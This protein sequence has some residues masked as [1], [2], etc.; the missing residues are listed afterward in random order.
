MKEKGR[1]ITDSNEAARRSDEIFNDDPKERMIGY[2]S[3]TAAEEYFLHYCKPDSCNE[4]YPDVDELDLV[5]RICEMAGECMLGLFS[6]NETDNP[7]EELE[8]TPT[9]VIK[10]YLEHLDWRRGFYI[11]SSYRNPELQ[12]LEKKVRILSDLVRQREKPF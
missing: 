5:C 2:I 7:E 1:D 4:A 11:G 8:D 9:A 6:I 12:S 3:G 10:E